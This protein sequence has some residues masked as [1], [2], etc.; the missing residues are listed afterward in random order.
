[1]EP[2]R[3]LPP[4]Q[5]PVHTPAPPPPPPL[6]WKTPP[7]FGIFSKTPTAPQEKGWGGGEGP[8]VGGWGGGRGPI[9]RENERP[10]R[11]KHL[12]TE[13]IKNIR[14][15]QR[16][17]RGS[18]CLGCRQI[19]AQQVEAEALWGACP[20]FPDFSSFPHVSALFPPFLEVAKRTNYSED[21]GLK[22]RFS[23]ATIAF[24]RESAQISQIPWR[25]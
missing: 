10:F 5:I 16:V 14:N 18:Y 11:R 3:P 6:S 9:Y 2:R 8:G 24:D 20:S 15:V 12:R 4:P 22:V 19:A 13:K 1:M 23:L 17:R 21:R 7:P 25:R